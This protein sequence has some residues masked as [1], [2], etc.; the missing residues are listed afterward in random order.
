MVKLIVSFANLLVVSLVAGVV[1]GVPRFKSA[2]LLVAIK[3]AVGDCLI[4][5]GV[6]AAGFDV[7]T[8]ISRSVK[9]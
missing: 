1:E 8:F 2:K 9:T 5:A 7:F 3:R 6:I 4:T